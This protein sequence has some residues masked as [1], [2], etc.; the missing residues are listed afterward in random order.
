[1]SFVERL[2]RLSQIRFFTLI[3]ASAWL[4]AGLLTGCQ[5][6]SSDSNSVVVTPINPT[7]PGT[8]DT[9]KANSA[10]TASLRILSPKGGDVYALGDSL[11]VTATASGNDQG[12]INAID[13]FLSP[14]GG[15]TWGT[16]SDQSLPVVAQSSV[17]FSWK[18]PT[19]F[20]ANGKIFSLAENSNC[21]IRIAQRNTSDPLKAAVSGRFMI[22]DTVFIRLTY[23]LGGESIKVGDSVRITW[24]VK[25][26]P[27]DP[28][29]AVDVMI[30][31]DSGKL[32]AYLRSQ[33][34][35]TPDS[36]QWGNFIW[37]VTD[38]VSSSGLK[39]NLVDN[40]GVSIKVEQY[41]SQDPKK[42]CQSDRISISRP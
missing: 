17:N 3:F 12:T 24:T 6:A 42:R 26:D 4:G 23:P 28:V 32:W 18:I 39:M 21:M 35:I 5:T 38:S 30:T 7:D 11:H 10:D 1:M 20:T 22:E 9:V 16:L 40:P 34:S 41:S 36:P 33:G 31:A 19:L 29:N 13:V 25:D 2:R 8:K 27:T 37:K 15:L 14:D